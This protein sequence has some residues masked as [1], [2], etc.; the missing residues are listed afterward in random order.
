MLA[1]MS[2]EDFKRAGVVYP[3][4]VLNQQEVNQILSGLF[5]YVSRMKAS[6]ERLA[7]CHAF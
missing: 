4:P 1:A 7:G 5:S 6:W 2:Q 3:I